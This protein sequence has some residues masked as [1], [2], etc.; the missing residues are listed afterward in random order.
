[1][2]Q[3]IWALG[4]H[5]IGENE[6]AFRRAV[7]AGSLAGA[8]ALYRTYP[9]LL[10]PAGQALSLLPE[11]A[12]L[13]LLLTQVE[14]FSSQEAEQAL[15]RPPELPTGDELE[16]LR[17]ELEACKAPPAPPLPAGL[18]VPLHLVRARQLAAVLLLAG[19]LAVAGWTGLRIYQAQ[20]QPVPISKSAQ[21]LP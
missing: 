21:V 9:Q 11:P 15:G 16:C 10:V 6:E 19:S 5:T 3:K 17:E 7:L 8:A 4:F 14:G 18:R 1:M 12:R 13:W 20:T 2:S